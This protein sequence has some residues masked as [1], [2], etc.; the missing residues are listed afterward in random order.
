MY[1]GLSLQIGIFYFEKDNTEAQTGTSGLKAFKEVPQ[2]L[3]MIPDMKHFV[4][5]QIR[6]TWQGI[7]AAVVIVI[8]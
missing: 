3:V 7:S 4:L 5:S 2:R 1:A 6:Y 8:L